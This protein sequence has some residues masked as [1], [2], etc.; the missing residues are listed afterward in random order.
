M[1]SAST[2]R[3]SA[4]VLSISMV[5]PFIARTMSP[6]RCALPPGMFST[7]GTTPKTLILGFMRPIARMAPMTE[8]P[9]D[10]SPFMSPM[11]AACFSEMPPVSNVIPLPTSATLL[12]GF[13]GS[14]RYSITMSFGSLALPAATPSMA[15]MPCVIMSSRPRTVMARPLSFA[16][17]VAISAMRVGVTTLAGSF[18]MSLVTMTLSAMSVPDAMPA[19][20]SSRVDA[21]CPTIVSSSSS[22]SGSS[23]LED[24]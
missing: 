14:P 13:C 4:S 18:T 21:S 17:A 6:G 15:P 24:L 2:S 3:P 5:L 12:S 20:S 19:F 9:P 7:A 8:A 23:P 16:T 11:P 1:A 22:A 10:M